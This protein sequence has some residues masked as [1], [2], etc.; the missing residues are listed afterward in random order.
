MA[1]VPRV[2]EEARVHPRKYAIGDLAGG[3]VAEATP[4][5]THDTRST[6]TTTTY[7]VYTRLSP[8]ERT[9]Q[10]SRACSPA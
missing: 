3:C 1:R 4:K 7:A 6:Q 5:K 10:R 8:S 9:Q 2:E